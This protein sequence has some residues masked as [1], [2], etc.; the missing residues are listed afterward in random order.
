MGGRKP[1]VAMPAYYT[2]LLLE[3][4]FCETQ[5]RQILPLFHIARGT[6]SS[7]FHPFVP[8]VND[9]AS[10]LDVPYASDLSDWLQQRVESGGCG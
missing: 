9:A 8:A 6:A 1:L 7:S 10:F 3:L 2:M 4:L 5:I